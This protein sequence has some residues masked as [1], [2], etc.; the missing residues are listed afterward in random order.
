MSIAFEDINIA[1]NALP[2]AATEFKLGAQTGLVSVPQKILLFATKLSAG[3]GAA[4]TPIK[5]TDAA[6]GT[7]LG[8]PRSMLGPMVERVFGTSASA[9]LTVILMVED[10]GGVAADG[11]ITFA[12]TTAASTKGL[13]LRVGGNPTNFVITVGD[14]PTQAAAALNTAL[15]LNG[16]VPVTSTPTVGEVA[17]VAAT[18]GTTQ[19]DLEVVLIGELPDGITAVITPLTSGAADP[20]LSTG[21][22]VMGDEDYT[23]CILPY[24]EATPITQIVAEAVARADPLTAKIMQIYAG[25]ADNYSDSTTFAGGVNSEYLQVVSNQLSGTPPWVFGAELAAQDSLN[26]NPA[27]LTKNVKMNVL[28]PLVANR[29]NRNQR[30]DL[31]KLGITTCF[32]NTSGEFILDRLVTTKTTTA[33]VEDF[34]LRNPT[35]IA[36]RRAVAKDFTAALIQY[37][38]N[39]IIVAEDAP[40]EAVGE[41]G[42]KPSSVGNF[43]KTRIDVQARQT[44]WSNPQAVKDSMTAEVSDLDPNSIVV[45][46][47]GPFSMPLVSIYTKVVH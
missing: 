21:I 1:D 19:N 26:P 5:V 3:T 6:D 24:T 2:T 35:V 8:G 14:S 12:G 45:R 47:E 43:L 38:V 23:K 9:D 34:R 32:T 42:V 18:K 33:S 30:N 27:V 15:G 25:I 46:F 4:L 11:D 10:A 13:T 17:L 31:T 7:T 41:L 44:W 40:S 16:T 39:L 36:L 20:D 22:A 29:F 28:T 37:N